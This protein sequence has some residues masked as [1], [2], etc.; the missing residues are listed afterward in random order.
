MT[1]RQQFRS[2]CLLLALSLFFCTIPLKATDMSAIRARLE[3]EGELA[4]IPEAKPI[5]ME[6]AQAIGSSELKSAIHSSKTLQ[7][8]RDRLETSLF[9][10][11]LKFE[12][13]VEN[14]PYDAPFRDPF[15]FRPTIE[16]LSEAIELLTL[17]EKTT[18]LH[19][20]PNLTALVNKLKNFEPSAL[21]SQFGRGLSNHGTPSPVT[22]L[23]KEQ[24][25]EHPVESYITL[26]NRKRQ[27]G[28]L[29]SFPEFQESVDSII[30]ALGSQE[31]ASFK[32]T[33]P[34]FALE[35]ISTMAELGA[36]KNQ[37][38]KA[39]RTQ[40]A[41]DQPYPYRR[42]IQAIERGLALLDTK[43]RLKYNESKNWHEVDLSWVR[44]N[45]KIL[46][47]Y[48][49]NRYKYH[50]F[51]ALAT[52]D[53]VLVPW[54]SDLNQTDLLKLRAAHLDPIGVITSTVRI[55]RHHNTPLD[56]WYHDVN[57]V[58]RMWYYDLRKAER[59]HLDTD[60]KLDAS[61]HER[62][63]FVKRF[64]ADT[65]PNAR[66]TLENELRK[67]ERVLVFETLHE[68]A[69]PPDRESIIQ[70]LRRTPNT[71]Q[72]FEIQIAAQVDNIEDIRTF[73]GNLKSGANQ[74]GLNLSKPTVVRYFYDR[75]PGYLSNVDN[76]L[77]WGFHDSPFNIN[78]EVASL[79]YRNPAILSLA[80]R[81]LG[82]RFGHVLP[83]CEKLLREIRDR[84]GQP[85][86]YNYYGIEDREAVLGH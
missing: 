28:E 82:R 8:M 67:Q 19:S 76:K 15:P 44:G 68:T 81:R 51:A 57:H 64:I 5:L 9:H 11:N 77:R 17:V 53:E 6:L 78:Q 13:V 23:S 59:E 62:E 73:D 71:P 46:P 25:L 37:S 75:A 12:V 79:E 4:P 22:P 1:T 2:P 49:F 27:N 21:I 20:N 45:P 26:R 74:L 3:A 42:T 43:E 7:I 47:L 80:A 10:L 14:Y 39:T 54:A 58:R 55:D 50:M 61:M 70:D 34:A 33:D 16:A 36:V 83:S 24:M 29:T 48:H 30:N 31:V 40:L 52:R 65:E 32:T 38:G 41:F 84:S 86:L 18:S 66:T 85:E 35:W 69:L 60:E 63:V 56:F 72:P